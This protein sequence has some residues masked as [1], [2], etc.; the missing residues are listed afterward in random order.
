VDD[1]AYCGEKRNDVNDLIQKAE[2]KHK[3]V[4]D[5]TIGVINS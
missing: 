2:A 3:V 4:F 5:K 1:D